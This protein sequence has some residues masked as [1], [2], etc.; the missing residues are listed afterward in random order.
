VLVIDDEP[1]YAQF[2]TDVLIDRGGFEVSQAHS[3]DEATELIRKRKFQLFVVDL[4]MPASEALEQAGAAS[5]TKTGLLLVRNIR[6]RWP[7]AK[8]VVHTIIPDPEAEQRVSQLDGVAFCYKTA[9]ADRLLSVVHRLLRPGSGSPQTFIVHGRDREAVLELKHFVQNRLRFKEPIILDEQRADGRTIIE[10]F[11]HYAAKADI[12]FVLLTPDDIGS[13]KDAPITAEGRPRMNVVFEFGYFLGALSRH[14]G[15]VLVLHK[16]PIE[17]PSDT[18][19][20]AFIDIGNGIEAAGERIRIE[21]GDW[22]RD[23]RGG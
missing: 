7:D 21:L 15:R 18:S 2:I 22:V 9:D 12:V 17:M 23:G 14:S 8:I 11:E 10:K 5:G 19:G 1:F 4:K 6:K 3:A 16:G 20:M 13:L